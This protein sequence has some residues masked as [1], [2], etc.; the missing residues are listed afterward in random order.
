VRTYKHL[1][2][3]VQLVEMDV[4]NLGD[5][6]DRM[7]PDQA[8]LERWLDWQRSILTG[9]KFKKAADSGE[10]I[11][12]SACA[13]EAERK[14]Y[15]DVQ[16][17][18]PREIATFW[19]E[20]ED[21]FDRSGIDDAFLAWLCKSYVTT[22]LPHIYARDL[23]RCSSP[24]CFRKD[25]TAHHIRSAA[26]G[27]GTRRGTSRHRVSTITSTGSTPEGSG[28]WAAR[29]ISSPGTSAGSPCSSSAGATRSYP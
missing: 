18:V 29:P 20:L 9:E 11:R 13:P 17:R 19:Q 4:R 3:E 27:A 8:R 22:W 6:A 26:T 25:C 7:P 15:V 16:L 10:A 28:S 5:E 23:Y 2:E 14:G 1:R 21:A 24:V 12:M